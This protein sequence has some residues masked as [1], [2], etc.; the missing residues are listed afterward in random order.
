MQRIGFQIVV[1]SGVADSRVVRASYTG[2]YV[3]FGGH[4][5]RP[6][7]GTREEKAWGPMCF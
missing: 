6:L 3:V 5:L 4:I 7:V 2:I 1:T